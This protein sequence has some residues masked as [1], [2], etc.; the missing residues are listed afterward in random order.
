MKRR[1]PLCY[2]TGVYYEP[3]EPDG[4]MLQPMNCPYHDLEDTN[5]VNEGGGADAR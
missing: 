2:D 1:C 3:V 4:S 5:K